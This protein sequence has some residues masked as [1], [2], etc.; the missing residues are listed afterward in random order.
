MRCLPSV[1]IVSSTIVPA[2]P[3]I[4]VVGVVARTSPFSDLPLTATIRSPRLRP[5]FL[6]GPPSK[7]CEDLEPARDLLDVHADALE[8]PLRRG[9]EVR[10]LVGVDVA[11]ERVVERVDGSRQRLVG[12]LLAVDLAVE[13]GLDAVED[14]LVDRARRRSLAEEVGQ[15]VGVAAD[16]HADDEQRP[17]RGAPAA[18]G[19]RRRRIGLH[20][21]PLSAYPVPTHGRPPRL[22]ED[23]PCGDAGARSAR[24][25]RRPQ[26]DLRRPARPGAQG[27]GRAL[28]GL[29]RPLLP[30]RLPARQP[31]P[32]LERPRLPRPLARGDRP[33]ARHQQLPRV[34]RPDLPGAVRVGL[35]AGHQRRPGDDQA[36]RVRDRPPRLGGGLDRP[37]RPGGAHGPQ[38]RRR[39]VR[40]RGPG[41]RPAAQPRRPHRRRVR[42]RRGHGRPAALRGAGREAREVDDRP[43]REGARGGGHRDPLRR[44]R[45]ARPRASRSCARSST[46][47]SSPP[48]RASRAAAGIEGE[49]LAGVYDAMRYLYQRNRAVAREEGRPAA[50]GAGGPGH[51]RHGPR[52]RR[53]R[54]RRHRDGL[55]V[56]GQPRGRPQRDDVRRLPRPARGRPLPGRAVARAPAPHVVDLRARRAGARAPASARACSASSAQDGRVAAVEGDEVTGTSSRDL[57]AVARHRVH[58]PRPTSC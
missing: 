29:R 52:R 53:H 6:A 10:V 56:V 21:R 32:G 39:R 28:H 9:L 57:R 13:V 23:P 19:A 7:T 50:R 31:D 34:H 46:R 51:L 24:A 17:A 15:T 5:A 40:P 1:T 55:R 26:G 44:R 22:P 43:A 58:R 11:A 2:G 54:R 38:G 42:A 33:A 49:D 4:C 25:R 35:R 37:G 8:V 36:G 3:L 18:G 20:G 12:D 45:R 41:R 47:S 27:P 48:A 16:P 14:V 30:R